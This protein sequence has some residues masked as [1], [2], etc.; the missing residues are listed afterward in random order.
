MQQHIVFMG[1]GLLAAAVLT[2]MS[3]LQ[4]ANRPHEPGGPGNREALELGYRYRPSG[5][6]YRT[7][8]HPMPCEPS[9]TS[10]IINDIM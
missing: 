1:A 10:G 5:R 3:H 8:R 2:G 9:L 4:A 7:L 6:Q